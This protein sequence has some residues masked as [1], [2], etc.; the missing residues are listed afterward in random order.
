MPYLQLSTISKVPIG[1][2]IVY[3]KL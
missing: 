2:W 1:N 3:V